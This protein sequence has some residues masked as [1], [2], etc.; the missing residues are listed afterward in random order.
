MS[1][2]FL[3]TIAILVHIYYPDTYKHLINKLSIF[4]VQQT[5][6]LVN[7]CLDTPFKKEIIK[8]FK[9]K[10]PSAHFISTTNIGKDIGGKIALIALLKYLNIQSEWLLLIHDKKSPQSV[11]GE[12]WRDDLYKIFEEKNLPEIYGLMKSKSTGI[13]GSKECIVK[14]TRKSK[15]LK[16]DPNYHILCEQAEKLNLNLKDFSFVGGTTFWIRKQILDN[17]FQNHDPLIIRKELEEGNVI[18]Y[19]RPK[20]TH[21]WERL[22]GLITENQPFKVIGF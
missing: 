7:I 11:D 4:R 17:F 16:N 15:N 12:R 20:I 6:L 22:F 18:D 10:F 8:A 9:E 14:Y 19:F 13:I 2:Q 1:P 5:E 3:P 21:T